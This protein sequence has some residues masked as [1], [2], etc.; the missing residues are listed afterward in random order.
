MP[1]SAASFSTYAGAAG[2]G[3]QASADL[4]SGLYRAQVARNNQTIANENADLATSRGNVMAMD[5][6]LR[7]GQVEGAQRAGFG[8]SGV[9]VNSGSAVRTQSDTARVGAMDATTIMNN[10]ARSAWGLKQQARDFGA[11]AQLD[12]MTGAMGGIR[13]LV[14]GA[15]DFASKWSQWQTAGVGAKKYGVGSPS[16]GMDLSGDGG[17]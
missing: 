2:S 3:L 1:Q 12:T 13:S 11:D 14:G 17:S 7:T 5:S 16:W 8:A 4:E 15:S 9:D 10:A 6:Q